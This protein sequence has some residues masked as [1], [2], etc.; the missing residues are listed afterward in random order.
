MSLSK[1]VETDDPDRSEDLIKALESWP[2]LLDSLQYSFLKEGVEMNRRNRIP[3]KGSAE[4]WCNK[5]NVR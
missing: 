1:I 2:K 4:Y 5:T 3:E